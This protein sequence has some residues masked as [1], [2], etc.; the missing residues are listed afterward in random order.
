MSVMPCCHDAYLWVCNCM[1][2]AQP[3]AWRGHAFSLHAE[4]HT[5]P[6]PQV[7]CIHDP[8]KLQDCPF[9]GQDV[10][11]PS[12][13]LSMLLPVLL[14]RRRDRGGRRRG[15]PPPPQ[16]P[17]AHD[18]QWRLHHLPPRRLAR[19]PRLEGGAHNHGARFS[20]PVGDGVGVLGYG[21]VTSTPA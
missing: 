4:R 18:R 1:C 13:H 21:A 15:A 2:H 19:Q 6:T 14:C 11:P 8:H 17:R 3:A 9:A 20:A 5:T 16:Q 12:F 10:T 7:L